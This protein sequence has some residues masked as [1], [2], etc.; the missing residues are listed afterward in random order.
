MITASHRAATSARTSSP[1]R[2]QSA[3]SPS[4]HASGPAITWSRSVLGWDR[5]R[6]RWLKLGAAITAV[7]IDCGVVPV[8]S[9]VV[10]ESNVHNVAIVQADA[11]T[12]DWTTLIDPTVAGGWT[13]VANLPYNVGTPLVCDVLDDV[14]PRHPSPSH[15]AA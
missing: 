1:T 15:G 6:L 11:M 13:L 2:T 5:S 14:P 10:K 12:T 4:S 8:L 7:E 9:A 3:G